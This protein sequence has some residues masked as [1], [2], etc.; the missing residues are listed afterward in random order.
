[1]KKLR[2]SFLILIAISVIGLGIVIKNGCGA[3][4]PSAKTTTTTTKKTTTTAKT[5]TTTTTTTISTTTTTTTTTTI[6]IPI[7]SIPIA[8]GGYHTIALDT[9][10]K[11]WTWGYNTYGQLGIGTPIDPNMSSYRGAPVLVSQETGLTSATA[12]AAGGWHT[13]AIRSGDGT[14]WAWGDNSFGQLGT[15]TIDPSSV[16]LQVTEFSN[17]AAIAAGAYHTIALKNDGTLWAWGN[18]HYGQLGDGTTTDRYTPVQVRNKNLTPFTG[19]VA[20]SAGGY[21][22]IALKSDGSLWTWGANSDGQLGTGTTVESHTPFHVTQEVVGQPPNLEVRPFTEEVIA[23]AA[24]GYVDYERFTVAVK[25]DSTVWA[26]G[27]GLSGQLGNAYDQYRY[28]PCQVVN[29]DF[30]PF[31]GA[32]AVAAGGSHAVA[33]KNDGTVW[34]W[35]SNYGGQLG[36]GTASFRNTPTP[37]SVADNTTI[38]AAGLSHT[39]VMK[40]GGTI[41]TCGSNEWGQLGIG[42]ADSQVHSTPTQISWP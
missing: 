20:I 24:G 22:N 28:L 2:L 40:S 8:G 15:G 35:G 33:L 25:I 17:V 19:V 3:V 14:V 27:Y 36:N 9:T 23:L 10:G 1:M 32:A 42:D 21:H 31:T 41:W 34:T 6:T 4:V 38:I 13:L 5:T 12:I 29:E 16:P 39:I 18:N 26:W 11:V 37:A 30:S 7:K